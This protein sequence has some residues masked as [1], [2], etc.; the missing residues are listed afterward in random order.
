MASKYTLKGAWQLSK[1]QS[2]TASKGHFQ[3]WAR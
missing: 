3:E 2:Y 1:Q